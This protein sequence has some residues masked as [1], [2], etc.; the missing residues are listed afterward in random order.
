MDAFSRF[1]LRHKLLIGL[2]WL[3]ATLAG[4]VA[5]TQV[6]DRLTE[7]FSPPG[8][9]ARDANTA[10]ARLYGT[11]GEDKPLVPVVTLP[12]GARVDDP[13]VRRALA[14][15]FE[16]GAE[17]VDGLAASYADTADRR[18]VGE[19]GRTT[20]GLVFPRAA[21][22]GDAEEAPDV[23]APLTEAMRAELPPGSTL[24]VTGMDALEEGAGSEGPSVLVETVIGG[25]GALVVLAFV[26][27]SPLA[28]VPLGVAVVSILTSFLAVYGITGV[29]E[30]NFM[31]QFVVALIGLGVAIDY[32]L[33]LVTRWREEVAHGHRGDEAVRR[34]MAT[35]GR[36]VVSSAVAVAIGLVVM[37]VLP[38]DFLRSIAYG[39]MIIPTVSALAT[40]TLLPVILATAGPRLD[41][42][43]LRRVSPDA[44]R[45]WTAWTRRVIRWRWAA[46]AVSLSLLGA[47][48]VAALGLN[49]GEAGSDALAKRGP[50]YEGLSA[51]DRA[52]IPSGVLTPVDVLV[53]QGVDPRPVAARLARVPGVRTVVAADGPGRRRDGTALIT[54]LPVDE[55]GTGP[56]K[57]TVTA[58]RDVVPAGA[59]VGGE[60]AADLDFIDQV[61]GTF[62]LMLALVALLTFVLLARAFRSLLLPLKAVLLNLLSLASVLGATVLVWQYGY[63]GEQLWGIS[64][65]G[66]IATFI[67]VMVFAFLYGLSMDYEVFILARIR[68]EYDRTGCTETAVVEGIGR[69]GRLVTSAAL[70]LFLA[71]ASLA[72]APII[73]VKIFA[74]GLGL[75]ILLDAT[76]IRAL[77]VPAVVAAL[78]RWNWWLPGWAARVLRVR[79]AT[80]FTM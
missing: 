41:R 43:G 9:P 57:D 18:F 39:G 37:L 17:R 48:A 62:P 23:T 66:S 79:P 8:S 35:A 46:I 2:L 14:R 70:I 69:T 15:A 63:G 59:R 20:F 73:E 60:A 58:I 45:A 64:A 16:A 50:A 22:G 5:V 71:F 75:G 78:G 54:V 6:T 40:L 7:D 52:G 76:I 1:V 77:L 12:S 42:R 28:L 30:V 31:V 13:A 53:P 67:P 68:E 29:T 47:L 26:F 65:T 55:G 80:P 34:A 44:G 24:R 61:Y 27:G 74:T 11:G 72:A 32:S 51:L 36:A 4:A 33:L 19:D 10:I 49:L 38:V 3:T 56:G 25:V 21:A